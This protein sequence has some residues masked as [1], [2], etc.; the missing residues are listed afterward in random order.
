MK[1][2]IKSGT[3]PRRDTQEPP[4]WVYKELHVR[5]HLFMLYQGDYQ[6]N[7]IKFKVLPPSGQL[8]MSNGGYTKGLVQ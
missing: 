6:L 1:L 8:N 5:W 3:T 4:S 2:V 7:H